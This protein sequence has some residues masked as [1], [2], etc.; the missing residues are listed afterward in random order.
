MKAVA[1]RNLVRWIHIGASAVIGTYIYAPFGDIIWFQLL[2]K[3]IVI[4][5]TVF[6]GLWMWKG[7][8]IRKYWNKKFSSKQSSN[9]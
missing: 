4:P 3:V 5:A 6:T 1:E 9:H 2:T 7:F 8:L